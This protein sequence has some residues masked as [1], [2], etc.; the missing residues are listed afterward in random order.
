MGIQDNMTRHMSLKRTQT[1][2]EIISDDTVFS[3]D[4]TP[5]IFSAQ[6][7]QMEIVKLLLSMGETI[8]VPHDV[9]CTCDK[10]DLQH[11]DEIRWA[12]TRLSS[13]RALASE[14]YITLESKDPILKTFQ[15]SR[16]LNELSKV[17]KHYKVR[18]MT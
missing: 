9:N 14:V 1:E 5:L 11:F 6:K 7:N 3:A 18:E 16:T 12:K 4:V 15:L 10:C 2:E 8:E 13:Y 17:E